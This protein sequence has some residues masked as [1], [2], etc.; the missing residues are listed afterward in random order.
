MRIPHIGLMTIVLL[1]AGYAIG[2]KWP[3]VGQKLG[4]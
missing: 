2:V 3:G 1:L 4:L